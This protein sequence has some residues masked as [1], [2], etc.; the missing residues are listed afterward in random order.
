MPKYA[1]L[2]DDLQRRYVEHG[3]P[4]DWQGI[5]PFLTEH[6][7]RN[8]EDSMHRQGCRG[9]GGGVGWQYGYTY[10]ITPRTIE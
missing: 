8:W 4:V 3:F 10:T 2:T 6:Q 1:G 5:G 7:A 9:D